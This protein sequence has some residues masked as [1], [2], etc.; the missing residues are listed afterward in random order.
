MAAGTVKWFN[1]ASGYG[2][3]VPDEGGQNLYVRAGNVVGADDERLSAGERVEFE[4]RVAGMGPE[5]IAVLRLAAAPALV[6]GQGQE[7]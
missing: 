3:I 1:E 5:A 4:S 7:R 6:G 2:F